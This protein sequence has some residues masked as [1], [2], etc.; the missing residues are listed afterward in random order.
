VWLPTRLHALC[1][2]GAVLHNGIDVTGGRQAGWQGAAADAGSGGT[3]SV[4]VREARAGDGPF[5]WEMLYEAIFVPPGD[6]P[7]PK[8]V[9]HD[10][11][12]SRYLERFPSDPGDR[13]WVAEQGVTP[14]GA[15]WYRIFPTPGFGFVATTIPELTIAVR[16]DWR[17]RGVG[18]L[19]LHALLEGARRD[20]LAGV[21]LS[22]QRRNRAWHLYE[23]VGFERVANL[24]PDFDAWT[25]LHRLGRDAGDRA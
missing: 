13:G 21:S 6:P 2:S 24:V 19:L 14:I 7:V 20:G 9:L 10:P 17:G 18:T 25:M 23:R 11:R 12:V 15:A 3:M 4:T 5:L 22:V 8:S 1:V 16:V